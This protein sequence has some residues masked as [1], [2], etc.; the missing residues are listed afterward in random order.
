MATKPKKRS[1]RASPKKAVAAPRAGK[2]KAT[3]GL[4]RRASAATK[5]KA[6]RKVANRPTTPRGAPKKKASGSK[7]S[8]AARTKRPTARQISNAA[9]PT[10]APALDA[11]QFLTALPPMPDVVRPTKAAL[12]KLGR[13]LPGGLLELFRQVGF[14]R[15]GQG[16]LSLFH[17][18]QLDETLADWLGGFDPWRVPFARTALGDL[19]YFRDLRTTVATRSGAHDDSACDV[20]LVVARYRKAMLLATNVGHFVENVLGNSAALNALLRKDLFDGALARLGPP[21]ADEIYGFVPALALGG[22]E[23]PAALERVKAHEHLATLLQL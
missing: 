9:W 11:S 17:P 19:V 6:A 12:A 4:T 20:T 23:E 16:F 13:R 7:A 10:G 1:S 22:S 8:K 5:K 21:S 2:G 15:F 14:G 18:H 3:K